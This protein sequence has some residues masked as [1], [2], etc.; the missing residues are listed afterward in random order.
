MTES[1]RPLHKGK[2]LF[3]ENLLHGIR[4]AGAFLIG[5]SALI[6]VAAI[7]TN[8]GIAWLAL[9][10][11]ALAILCGS[12]TPTVKRLR[13]EGKAAKKAKAAQG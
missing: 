2:E 11:G 4:L 5:N 6:A 8:P 12:W 3:L 10:T 7:D 13:E 9:V 1:N